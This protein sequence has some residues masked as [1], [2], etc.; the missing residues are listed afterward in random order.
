[1]QRMA[2]VVDKQNQHDSSYS[3]MAPD[4]DKNLAMQ[5][6]KQLIFKGLEQPNGYT[7]PTLHDFR[8]QAK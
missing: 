5:A 7:E 4:S 3:P 1:M 2:L 8:Q 6:A